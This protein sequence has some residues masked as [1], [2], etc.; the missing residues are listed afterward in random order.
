MKGFG[1]SICIHIQCRGPYMVSSCLGETLPSQVY[2]SM[3]IL[4]VSLW[5]G[6][7]YWHY[8]TFCTG[9]HDCIMC[10]SL[11]G[12]LPCCLSKSPPCLLSPKS[13]DIYRSDVGIQWYPPYP[14]SSALVELR[15]S[16]I[17]STSPAPW[18]STWPFPISSHP[19]DVRL[20]HLQPGASFA[21]FW[22]QSLRVLPPPGTNLTWCSSCCVIW[23]CAWTYSA[24]TGELVLQSLPS[25]VWFS[26][27]WQS[28]GGLSAK[29][30]LQVL[31]QATLYKQWN[32][33]F[34]LKL[35]HQN[36]YRC[37]FY[38]YCILSSTS[39]SAGAAVISL[40]VCQHILYCLWELCSINEST[41]S[42]GW[43]SAFQ[44][45]LDCLVHLPSLLWRFLPSVVFSH[46]PAHP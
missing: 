10:N 3:M 4:L 41:L 45:W 18:T 37:Q 28:V 12:L 1:Q 26:C 14:K 16:G 34:F 31:L 5:C 40:W 42:L 21:L 9:K 25:H 13:H 11:F 17:L 44:V 8:G 33:Q 30:L 23:S 39:V 2:V 24:K 43:L 35:S 6:P 20:S 15:R 46:G 32:S 7:Q 29:S 19:K 36:C 27:I 38:C 22:R